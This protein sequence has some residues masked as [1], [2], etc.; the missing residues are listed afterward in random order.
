MHP[1]VV[2]CLFALYPLGPCLRPPADTATTPL[3]SMTIHYSSAEL[4]R[5]NTPIT[6]VYIPTIKEHR[7]L[8]LRPRY[9]HRASRCK[10][11]VRSGNSIPSLLSCHRPA[12]TSRDHNNK[13]H[14][15]T[16]CLRS[17]AKA[18]HSVSISSHLNC[19]LFYTHSF[20]LKESI[21]NSFITD[22]N[23][24]FICITETWQKPL[25]Y[26]SLNKSTPFGYS[27]MDKPR[28]D[29]RG[30]GIAVIHHLNSL[31]AKN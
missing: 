26:I 27:Y 7:L 24:D 30:G 21:I 17:I 4:H 6:S 18:P 5:L 8:R 29:G 28:L 14:V 13:P 9:V 20:N 15:R 3:D 31:S 1:I 11:T 19:A 22:N 16:D 12:G 23:L 25:E 2:L 10:L